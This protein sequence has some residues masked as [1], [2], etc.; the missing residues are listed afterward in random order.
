MGLL[1]EGD[2]CTIGPSQAFTYLT[3]NAKV[4]KYAVRKTTK[5]YTIG[6][7]GLDET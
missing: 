5:T 1:L 4:E 3:Y 7:W 6:Y 2:C